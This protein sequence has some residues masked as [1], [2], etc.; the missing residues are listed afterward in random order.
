MNN[1]DIKERTQLVRMAI[2]DILREAVKPLAGEDMEKHQAARCI[3]ANGRELAARARELCALKA[4]P[5]PIDSVLLTPGKR[6]FFDPTRVA[7]DRTA[8]AKRRK[9][10]RR[11]PEPSK[12]VATSESDF[13]FNPIPAAWDPDGM[14]E[15]RPAQPTVQ[16]PANAK[17][18]SLSVGGVTIRIELTG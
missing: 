4:P 13:T 9:P 2:A 12:I 7:V 15:E 14:P 16:L 8:G 5:F 3:E 6:G 17:S 18:I 10:R 1:R 11:K